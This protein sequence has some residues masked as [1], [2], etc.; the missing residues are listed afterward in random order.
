MTRNA[1]SPAVKQAKGDLTGQALISAMQTSPHRDIDI[2]PRRDPI[3]V[4]EVPV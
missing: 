1:K 3:S 4:R 2:E